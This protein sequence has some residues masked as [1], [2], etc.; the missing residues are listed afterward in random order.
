MQIKKLQAVDI[1]TNMH[2]R[3]QNLAKIYIYIFC[4]G[5]G[6]VVWVEAFFFF[7]FVMRC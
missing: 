2:D 7:P 6:L 3:I 1:K 4:H 5:S